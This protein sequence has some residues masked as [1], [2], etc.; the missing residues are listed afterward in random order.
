MSGRP[1]ARTL[2]CAAF[3][4]VAVVAMVL[5]L[6]LDAELL[7]WCA[8]ALLL[9]APL[10]AGRFPGEAVIEARRHRRARPR[11]R[12]RTAIVRVPRRPARAAIRCGRLIA[13]RLAERGPPAALRLT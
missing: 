11:R 5:R 4:A 1:A 10:L 3:A 13:L 12:A 2:A 9:V 8:P 7:L 6:G